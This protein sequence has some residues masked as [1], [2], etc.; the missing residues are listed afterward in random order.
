MAPKL[1]AVSK[2]VVSCKEVNQEYSYEVHTRV[3]RDRYPDYE[4]MSAGIE[5]YDQGNYALALDSFQE[6]LKYSK[7]NS[8]VFFYMADI[9]LKLERN[10]DFEDYIIKALV[11]GIGDTATERYRA[12]MT[13]NW[14]SQKEDI[15]KLR[16][17]CQSWNLE[18]HHG[19]VVLEFDQSFLLGL[20]HW[21]LKK[22]RE[23]IEI[24]RPVAA[25][26]LSRLGFDFSSK[27]FLMF[28][29]CRVIRSDG[30]VIA[31]DLERFVVG[32]SPERNIYITTEEEKVGSWIMPDLAS[33]DII[34]LCYHFLGRESFTVEEN[35]VPLSIVS[36]VHHPLYPTFIGRTLIRMPRDQKLQCSRRD[37]E[38]SIE[39]EET[40]EGEYQNTSLTIH[41]YVPVKNTNSYFE[42]YVNNPVV[43]CA[44]EKKDWPDIAGAVLINNFGDLDNDENLP[45]P[46]ADF[47][48]ADISPRE[49]LRKTFYWIRDQLKYASMDSAV[50]LI[51]TPN[52]AEAIIQS[53]VADCKDKTYLLRQ[54]CKILGLK[55][56][57]VAVSS[58]YGM[59]FDDLP[60][61]QFDH[62]FIRVLIDDRWHYL[63]AANRNAIFGS[64]PPLY[65]GLDTLILTDGVGPATIEV[66]SPDRNRISIT[67]TFDR[68]NLDWLS[69][70]Y[71]LEAEGNIARLVD[72]SLKSQSLQAQDYLQAA[73]AV[74]RGFLP[75][76]VL[77][78]FDR[79]S[80]TAYSDFFEALGM[81]HRC[82]LSSIGKRLVGTI[83]WDEPTT[84]TGYWKNFRLDHGFVFYQPTTVEINVVLSGNLPERIT[85]VSDPYSLQNELCD[86]TTDTIR[87]DGEIIMRRK[88][89]IKEKFAGKDQLKLVA[90]TMEGIEKAFQTAVIVEGE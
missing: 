64:C 20:N 73:Q 33:G 61:D 11:H 68:I 46:L 2:V 26:M 65:Q 32:D 38:T 75:S 7:E 10:S 54:V 21:Y 84:P 40:T 70:T 4:I 66:D 14:T 62:V 27:E 45:S 3:T 9:G 42:S 15:D 71:H 1:K 29:G 12:Y 17:E 48:A 60:S 23:V 16:E 41:R 35:R 55:S 58:K 81:H 59:V 79:I 36:T 13:N 22:T 51:G 83:E 44:T 6:Y 89:V 90:P 53:G 78:S 5:H 56:Q 24:R 18:Q 39:T 69:G 49:A 31:L 19:L 57:L 88:V 43:A 77:A 52:R 67:E 80:H 34:E 72:E 37:R 25:R 86:I 85:D 30:T 28:T 50:K 63:D 74:L 82:Q 47:A 87:R 8:H 76:A